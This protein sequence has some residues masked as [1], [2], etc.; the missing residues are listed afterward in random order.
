[1]PFRTKNTKYSQYDIIVK[2]CRLRGSTGTEDYEEAT[3]IEAEIRA[4]AKRDAQ[5]A[6]EGA[7]TLSEALGTDYRDVSQHQPSAA[8]T[9][10]QSKSLIA[11]IGGTPKIANVTNA[12][13][14][15][16]VAK[17][18]ATCENAT[19]KRQLQILGRALRHMAEFYS[20]N[21]PEVELRKPEAKE[22]KERIR[23]LSLYEQTRLF[24]HLAHDLRAPVQFSLMTGARIATM[25]G[26]LWSDNHLDR[27]EIEFRLKGIDSM[28]FPI[29]RE[30]AAF[31]SALPRS[32]VV[33]ARRFV[34]TRI[35]KKSLERVRIV[36]KGGVFNALFRQAI[37]DAEILDFRFHDL[38]HTL[39]T[40][41]L[42]QTRDLKLVGKLLGHKSIETTSRYAHVLV[43][44]MRSDLNSFS[45]LSGG[46]PQN[47]P[48]RT[49]L[50]H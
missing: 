20:A 2:G 46:V 13:I 43:D 44:D 32:N 35:D 34:F 19:V 18:R 3:A 48:Q 12:D 16:F 27:M 26:L 36:P 37:A 23:E 33:E 42:R 24:K 39:A 5:E 21:I 40:R 7:Y 41:M 45:P 17:K 11:G 30:M 1:M 31:L 38:R 22:P 28:T 49:R 4:D 10:S 47:F 8:T 15:S 14:L 6:A 25:A 50:K 9:A 29:S